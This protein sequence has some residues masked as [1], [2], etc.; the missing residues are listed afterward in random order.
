MMEYLVR[1]RDGTGP[2]LIDG[3]A[4]PKREHADYQYRHV[5]APSLSD[6]IVDDRCRDFR[7]LHS[8]QKRVRTAERV[9]QPARPPHCSCKDRF[10]MNALSV[11][12]NHLNRKRGPDGRFKAA[13]VRGKLLG[14]HDRF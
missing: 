3:V 10:P 1:S 12:G 9:V 5:V 2:A 14:E 8:L 6:A 11:F 4:H 13:N 7:E